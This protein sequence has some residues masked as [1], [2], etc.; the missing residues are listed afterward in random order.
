M[1]FWSHLLSAFEPW[2]R[3]RFVF[4]ELVLDL[5]SIA[6]LSAIVSGCIPTLRAAP[7][8]SVEEAIIAREKRDRVAPPRRGEILFLGGI[9]FTRPDPIGQDFPPSLTIHGRGFVGFSMADALKFVER[10][11]IV[12]QP[13][14][15]VLQAGNVD[16]R[17]GQKP[18][19]VL[20][21]FQRYVAAVRSRLPGTRILFLSITPSFQSWYQRG[22]PLQL[23]QM[24]ADYVSKERDL[25]YIDLWTPMIGPTGIPRAELFESG[26]YKFSREGILL[27]AKVILPHL[28]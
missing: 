25:G 23:N 11:T 5:H 26:S 7:D 6:L 3:F 12:Y 19:E 4:S 14:L 10:T 27:R 28:Q 17:E 9:H 8:L 20:R 22:G 2:S 21:L 24:I 15:I 16:L 13:R 18:E 1:F